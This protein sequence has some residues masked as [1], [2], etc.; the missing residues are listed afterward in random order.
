[1][2]LSNYGELKTS[3]ANWLG[4]ADL[5]TLIPDFC[6]L[7]HKQLMR[8][9]RDH[10]RLQ[11]RNASFSITGEYVACP[12]TFTRLRSLYL[13]TSP[14]RT[15][16][17][18]PNDAQTTNYSS[19]SGEPR[20]VSIVGPTAVGSGDA[21][22][23]SEYFRFAPIPDATYTATIEYT[24]ALAFFTADSGAGSTNWILTDNPDAYLYGALVQATAYVKDDPRISL[25]ASAY[26]QALASL[27]SA[28]KETRW[29]GNNMAVRV[30]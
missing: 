24:A 12:A 6:T 14:R 29:G 16:E 30:A 4:R 8:E 20:F 10:P 7:A 19:G 21:A 25:W 22:G 26:Q 13:N 15:V 23:S 17:F 1:M 27:N 18:M 3:V 9:L 11:I 2:A 28:G 5:T